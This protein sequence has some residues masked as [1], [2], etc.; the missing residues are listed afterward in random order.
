MKSTFT[1]SINDKIIFIEDSNV[2]MSVTNDIENVIE[3]ISNTV[4]INKHDIIYRD[5]NG[6]IDGIQIVDGKFHDFYFIGETE[7]D[8]AILKIKT[9]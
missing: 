8:K 2:G 9:F 6:V 1:Y 7:L 5:S 3:S 4:D